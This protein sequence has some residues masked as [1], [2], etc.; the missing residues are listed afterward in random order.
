MWAASEFGLV[1]ADGRDGNNEIYF[2]RLDADGTKLGAE[3]RVTS[4]PA[5]SE[6]PSLIGVAAGYAVAWND[7][8]DTTFQVYMARLDGLE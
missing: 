3:V 7:T 2:A 5:R 4:D 6:F 1:W 8:R